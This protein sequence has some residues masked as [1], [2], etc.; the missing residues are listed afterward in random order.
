MAERIHIY[1]NMKGILIFLVVFG[2]AIEFLPGET[3]EILYRIIY[4]FHMPLFVFCSGYFARYD[5][6]RIMTK[7]LYPYVVFQ[8][9]HFLF[10]YFVLG[11]DSPLQFTTPYW[12]LWYILALAVWTALLPL[13]ELTTKRGKYVLIALCFVFGLL[14]GYDETVD[15]YLSV[16]RII[17]FLPFFLMGYE[18]RRIAPQG[19]IPLL[20]WPRMKLLSLALVAVVVVLIVIYADHIEANWFINSKPYSEQGSSALVRLFNYVGAC[21]FLLFALCWTPE[22]DGILARY[23]ERSLGIYLLHCFILEY[24]GSINLFDVAHPLCL[25]LGLSLLI[26]G[27]LGLK[28]VAWGTSKFASWPGTWR[29]S[30]KN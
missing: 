18:Y 2:H 26:T 14:V 3:G 17:V 7:L 8:L 21:A 20:R 10:N 24:L 25:A 22:R 9:L 6:K 1:D 5:G 27:I 28:P 23:G 30:A 29:K 11:N 15:T 4:I 13:L 19:N 12:T 16:S